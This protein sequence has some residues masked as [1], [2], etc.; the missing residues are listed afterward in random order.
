MTV[1]LIYAYWPNRPF[2]MNWCDLPLA[3]REAGL[4][5]Q[6][7]KAQHHVPPCID[8]KTTGI[9]LNLE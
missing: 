2:G 8:A 3:L 4:P 6:L 5:E 7:H 1:C 9:L